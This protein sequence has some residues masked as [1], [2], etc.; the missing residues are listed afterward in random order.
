MSGTGSLESTG[1][2]GEQGALSVGL[3]PGVVRAVHRAGISE[4]EHGRPVE[5]R[6]LGESRELRQGQDAMPVRAM[7]LVDAEEGVGESLGGL[8]GGSVSQDCLLAPRHRPRQL[9][10]ISSLRSP[11]WLT[12]IAEDEPLRG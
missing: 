2:A 9:A 6:R 7:R 5:V 8:R 12:M 4:D 10:G 3:R 1:Q 11:C